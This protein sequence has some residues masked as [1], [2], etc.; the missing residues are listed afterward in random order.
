[1]KTSLI[2]SLLLCIL[3]TGCATPTAQDRQIIAEREARQAKACT[4]SAYC[5]T[6]TASQGDTQYR[7][8]LAY[9]QKVLN[10]KTGQ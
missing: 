4:R 6:I 7:N 2:L 3:A 5:G 1:M 9:A 10:V 8:D